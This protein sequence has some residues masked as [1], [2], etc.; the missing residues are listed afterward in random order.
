MPYL[1]DA[2]WMIQALA[3]REPAA[4]TLRR[5]ASEAVTVSVVTLAEIYEIAFNS[6]H[7]EGHLDT[8]RRFVAPFSLLPVSPPIAERF[9]EIR[10]H[11]RRRGEL[12]ADFDILVAAT[13]LHHDLTLL[14][15]NARHFR[16]IP[17]LRLFPPS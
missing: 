16:R 9:A 4:A 14:T 6:P 17:D 11:L 15:F 2:D 8:F 13:A 3:G 1:L 12:L 7:P 5:L 10:A